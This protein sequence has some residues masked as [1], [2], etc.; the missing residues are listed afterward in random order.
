MNGTLSFYECRFSSGDTMR[1]WAHSNPILCKR[2]C[3]NFLHSQTEGMQKNLLRKSLH[4]SQ[5]V[6]LIIFF[7]LALAT[8]S[9]RN[10]C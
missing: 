1:W 10:A 3:L 2:I 4:L 8:A 5:L 7:S 9:L 6:S